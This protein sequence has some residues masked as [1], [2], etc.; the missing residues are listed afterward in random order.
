MDRY[1]LYLQDSTE[2]RLMP[3]DE[4][5]LKHPCPNGNAPWESTGSVIRLD[6]SE[7]VCLEL[8]A[9]VNHPTSNVSAFDGVPQHI[10]N[11]VKVG[12]LVEYVWK[13]TSFDR[14]KTALKTFAKDETSVSGYLYH[15]LLGH[16][17]AP[18]TLKVPLPTSGYSVNGLPALNDSQINAVKSV[19]QQPLSLIQGPPGTGK[20]VTTAAIVYHLSTLCHSQVLVAAPSNVAVDQLADKISATGLKVR[21]RR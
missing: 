19:I 7:E 11:D 5:R 17:L 12:F 3:G 4:L 16:E 1:G 13:A 9:T 6:P 14:M 21:G 8:R 20:T 15:K 2:L 18:Q 10:P